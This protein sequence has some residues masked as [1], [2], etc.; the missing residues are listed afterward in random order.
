MGGVTTRA[1]AQRQGQ[2]VIVSGSSDNSL[3]IW[4]LESSG[5]VQTIDVGAPIANIMLAPLWSKNS[6]RR[7]KKLKREEK[8]KILLVQERKL[9]MSTEPV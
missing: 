4:D 9:Q 8:P 1:V 6:S 5:M 7:V 3:R 2:T